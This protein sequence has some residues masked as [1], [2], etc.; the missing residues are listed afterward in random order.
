V[1]GDPSHYWVGWM[2]KNSI[3]QRDENSYS[4][5]TSPSLRSLNG[6]THHLTIH[7]VKVPG[8]YTCQVYSFK[9]DKLGNVTHQ[10]SVKGMVYRMMCIDLH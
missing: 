9:G 1:S 10:V 4:L 3:I 8:K 5:S 2:H 7:S 6:T